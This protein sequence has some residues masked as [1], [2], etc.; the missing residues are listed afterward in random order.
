M[1]LTVSHKPRNAPCARNASMQ[2]AEHDGS[3]LQ[4]FPSIGDNT[5]LYARTQKIS[6]AHTTVFTTDRTFFVN[7]ATLH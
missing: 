7:V 3:N 2:Y 1:R 4:Q 5:T 6:T